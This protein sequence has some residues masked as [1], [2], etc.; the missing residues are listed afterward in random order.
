MPT[1]SLA[2]MMIA[3]SPTKKRKGTQVR[4]IGVLSHSQT[5]SKRGIEHARRDLIHALSVPRSLLG[6]LGPPR[7]ALLLRFRNVHARGLLAPSA[8]GP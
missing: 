5:M 6:V 3:I 1:S 8:G 2:P 7:A 4:R